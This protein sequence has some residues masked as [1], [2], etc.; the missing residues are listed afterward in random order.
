[1]RDSWVKYLAGALAVLFP[2]SIVMA[3]ANSAMLSASG[4]VTVNGSLIERTTAIFSGDKVQT[5]ANSIATLTSEGSA[6]TVP[7]NSSLIFS[8]SSVNL[9]SGGALVSTSR[10]MTVRVNRL[11]V[12]PARGAQARFQIAQNQ[13]QLEI[14]A[15]EGTLAI[16]NGI[17]TI[18]LQAGGV[19]TAAG[20]AMAAPYGEGQGATGSATAQESAQHEIPKNRDSR[21]GTVPPPG[22]VNSSNTLLYTAAAGGVAGFL[23][24]LSTTSSSSAACTQP[25][26]ASPCGP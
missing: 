23:V 1:M 6:V 5:G 26:S 18:A 24:Y 14:I 3:D 20:A 12:Q 16:D 13:G 8:R 19:F 2:A 25:N 11:L 15:R 9:L 17:K 4:N 10:G 21:V 7:G 22:G